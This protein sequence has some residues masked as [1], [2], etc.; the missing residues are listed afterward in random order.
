MQSD[1]ESTVIGPAGHHEKGLKGDAIGFWDGVAI[2]VDSTAPAYSMAA[3]LG[4]LVVIAG[5]KAPAML[6]ISF[7]PMFLIAGAFYYMNRADQDCGTT[8]S[9][10]TRAMG[11]WM[12]WMGG[13]AVFTTG[14]IVVGAQSD[15]AAYYIMNL[16]DP[17]L[18]ADWT[19]DPQ[20]AGRWI[21]MPLA[22]LLTVLMTWICVVGTELSAKVQRW[23]VLS[24]VGALLLF[25]VMAMVALVRGKGEGASFSLGWFI[26]N[27]M[28]ASSIIQAM[29]LGVFMYWGWESAVN[30]NEESENAEEAPGKAA[31]VSTLLLLFIYVGTAVMMVAV[32]DRGLIEEYDDDAGLFGA[33]AQNVMGFLW[34][35]LVLSVVISGAGF[36][37]DHDP[38]GLADLVVDG[39]RQGLPEHVPR[40]APRARH[41]GQGHL[42]DRHRHHVLVRRRIADLR[43]F[44]LG[45]TVGPV[46]RGGLLLHAH[47][48]G[49]R[50][51]L[52][53]RALPFDP[54]DVD[55]RRRSVDRLGDPVRAAAAVAIRD[56]ANPENSYTA[57]WRPRR[58]HA[59]RHRDLP[60]RAGSGAHVRPVLLSRRPRLLHSTRLRAG[61]GRGRDS[62]PRT[63]RPGHRRT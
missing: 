59:A 13:W 38:A 1:N 37:A 36:L 29:L 49:V 48:C 31:V 20:D 7:I 10:V 51:L 11:P 54:S 61:L 55:G 4:S 26:P 9:W 40:G 15:V 23:M 35:V 60:V 16:L 56:G 57:V 14:V 41:P 43:Q 50:D 21:R 22:I 27:E 39:C 30:L 3:V 46:D 18:H 47:R 53:Q 19:A 63:G 58:G 5:V 45:L 52:A 62:R 24:Q 42:G 28:S 12:G 34:P 2:G 25:I 17:I 8:F 33:V 32:A 6:L 44:P